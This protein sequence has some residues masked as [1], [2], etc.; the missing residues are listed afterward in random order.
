MIKTIS[1]LL[2]NTQRLLKRN[3]LFKELTDLTYFEALQVLY[4]SP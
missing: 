3:Y 1:Y 4:P 2:N